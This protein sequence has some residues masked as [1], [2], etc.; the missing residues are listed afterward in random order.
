MY[1][2]D[3]LLLIEHLTYMPG[4]APIISILDAEGMKV[5]EYLDRIDI[6]ALDDEYIYSTQMNGRD[7][8]NIILAMKKNP[9][10]TNAEIVCTHL[11]NAFGAGG[12][13]SIVVISDET[14]T[15]ENGRREAVVAFRGTA[16]NEW[17]DDFEGA[18]QIDSLQQINALEW[19]KQAY[20]FLDLD[21]YYVTVIG[22]SKGGN[23]AKYVTILNDTPDR[24]VSFDGQGFSDKFIEH[25]KR[26]IVARQ[27]V[28][29]NHNIDFDY[30]N[31]L[32]NDI[33]S[34]TYYIGY[35]YGKSGFSE[36]HAPNTF[37]DFGENGE[38][39]IRVNPSGQR[40]EMQ[41]VD[42]F[43]NSMIRSAISEK[44]GAETNTLVGMIVEK[45][46]SLSKGCSFDEFVTFLCDMIGNPKYSDNV[47]YLLAYCILYSRKNPDLL[48]SFRSIM[49]TFGSEDI[50]K[51]ID[52]VEDMTG[53]KKLNALLG[54]T[55]FLVGHA[56]KPIVRTVQNLA[57]KKYDIDLKP[58]QIESILRIATLTRQMIETLKINMDGSDM[59]V[60]N[61]DLS[62]EELREFVLP[63]NLDIVVLAGGL[64][65]ERN[66]SLKTGVT[67]AD[68]LRSRGNNVILL[69]AFMGYG[70]EEE[71]LPD[72]FGNPEKY[73]LAPKDIPD[74]IPDLWATRK[75]R[76][77]QSASYFGPNVLQIC[78]QSDLIFIALHGANGENGKVQAA[79]D[80]LGLDYTGCDYWSSAIS[81]NKSAAKELMKTVGVP[82]PDG[83]TIKKGD[84]IP[85]PEEMGLEY[86][87]IV[88]PNNGGIGLGVSV[89]SDINAYQKAVANAF[90]WDSEIMVE[91]YFSG[92]E[93]AVCTV[94]GK[95]LPV[96]EKLP[97][98]TGDKEKALS[99][100]GETV[101][102]CPAD[103]PEELARSLQKAAEDV[104]S[105]LGTNAYCKIDFMVSQD[106]ESFVC[107][108]CDSLPQL[109]P[110]SQLVISAKASGRSLGDL[111]DKI[112]EIS[113]VKKVAAQEKA[114]L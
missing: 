61:I 108:E 86:P 72:V 8:R 95:A 69:D 89:A 29:E 32:M 78:R 81:S 20:K 59:V 70:K 30:V 77:D 47:A 68:I 7:F 76:T 93:F 51:I 6:N 28:I 33:G 92:R 15:D 112:M 74:E 88:K 49:T 63:G 36:S 14:V 84:N 90:H 96:L 62:E 97:F 104:T 106:L 60:E 42:Q 82:V 85:N 44:E 55:D 66:L 11:D 17:T 24:C 91:D 19:Y 109:Y 67:V 13:I 38:Y 94:E 110:D 64:S 80:L 87:I 45:A 35:D 65:N 100:K 40:P 9:S 37:F 102:K 105:V 1:R 46:F 114:P 73:S 3:E 75:R 41:I 2:T 107:L 22:H 18:G 98:Q 99:R 101:N 52:M 57:K 113:L 10:I 43:I 23:K 103:I 34:K 50:L 21:Q 12:G 56:S 71:L 39:N 26:R 16:Q 5:G 4:I 27:S 83:Y 111:L 54:V 58:D 31:I 79:F 48:D 25:Y 53:S